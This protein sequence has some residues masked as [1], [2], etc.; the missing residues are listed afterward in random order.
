MSADVAKT[1]VVT[2]SGGM[3]L[4]LEIYMVNTCTQMSGVIH[5]EKSQ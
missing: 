2:V 4:E 5:S 1:T 3:L